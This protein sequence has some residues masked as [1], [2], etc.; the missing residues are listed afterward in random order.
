MNTS[1]KNMKKDFIAIGLYFADN[2]LCLQL[3]DGR[4]MRVP[5]EFYPTL[6]DATKKQRENFEIIGLGTGIHW[7]DI[8]E[9]LSVQGI[10]LGWPA[11]D[12]P[13][14]QTSSE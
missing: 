7:P 9:D 1:A 4:E 14:N 8:D 12:H 10:V 3:A 2:M 6:R 13:K 5:L 11:V